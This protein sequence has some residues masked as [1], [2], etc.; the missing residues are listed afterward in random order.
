M[1]VGDFLEEAAEVGFDGRGE[2]DAEFGVDYA[3]ESEDIVFVFLYVFGVYV[4]AGCF[5]FAEVEPGAGFEGDE[6]FGANEGQAFE[7]AP[8][9]V[10]PL[11]VFI[12]EED[13]GE[14]GH[15]VIEGNGGEV[16][17]AF[18]GQGLGD[19]GEQFEHGGEIGMGGFLEAVAYFAITGDFLLLVAAGLDE[20]PECFGEGGV[21]GFQQ[22]HDVE[23]A[24]GAEFESG[25]GEEEVAGGSSDEDVAIGVVPKVITKS[26]ESFYHGRFSMRLS[27]ANWMRSSGSLW[28]DR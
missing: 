25:F 18:E 16:V 13:C 14:I 23:V 27:R 1:L 7:E 21:Q 2:R 22:K 26:G 10:N 5:A 9:A 28:R 11:V 8:A 15:I 17:G 3:V 12:V 4:F 19:P 6:M 24:G 20:F